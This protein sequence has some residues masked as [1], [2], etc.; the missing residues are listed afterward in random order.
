MK[1]S[2]SLGFLPLLTS[3][4]VEKVT[5]SFHYDNCVRIERHK[6]NHFSVIA[7]KHFAQNQVFSTSSRSGRFASMGDLVEKNG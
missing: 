4:I 5:I 1:A 7:H 2:V 6:F 3:E